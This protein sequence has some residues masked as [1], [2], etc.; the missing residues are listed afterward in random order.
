MKIVIG[1]VIGLIA[2]IGAWFLYSEFKPQTTPTSEPIVETPAEIPPEEIVEET[3]EP[4]IDPHVFGASVEGRD[5]RFE[6]FGTGTKNILL[7]GGIHGGYEWNTIRLA[8]DFVAYFTKYPETIPGDVTLTIV[9]MLNIDGLH[10]VGVI[11][12]DYNFDRMDLVS[13]TS[14]GRFNANKVDLNR[15]FDC[16]WQPTA[17]WQDKEVSAGT[18]PFSEPE[19]AAI[20]DLILELQPEISVFW[21]SASNA[22]Y[23]SFCGDAG[24]LTATTLYG[25]AYAEAA[26]Y[27]WE[28]TFDHYVV[29][30]DVADWMATVGLAGISVELE[31]HETIEW[32]KNLA[33]VFELLNRVSEFDTAPA[34][35]M[36]AADETDTTAATTEV[37]DFASCAAVTGVVMQSYPAKCSYDGVTYTEEI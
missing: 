35:E 5:L 34:V 1:I 21:H 7:I 36:D 22:V 25:E 12:G 10:A 26:G 31:T 20:R 14:V 8:Q 15:N 11:P 2:A 16:Q 4:V 33:G 37:T 23:S 6:Q 27:P 19:A 32:E 28:E 24:P 17:T 30:G 3:I 29:T 9:P 13:E 18:A